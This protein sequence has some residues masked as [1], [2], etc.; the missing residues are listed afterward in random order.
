M[1]NSLHPC[2]LQ[3]TRPSCPS[4]TPG[5]YT[6]I[7]PLSQWCHPT[8]SSS[9][10]LFY[11][12][13]QFFPTSGSFPMSQ[14][15]VSGGQSIGVSGST[16]VLPMNTQDWSPL[17]WTGWIS[18]QSKGLSRVVSNTTVQKQQF[19]G[20]QLSLWSNS[21]IHMTTGNTT[22]MMRRTFVRKVMS[23]LFNMLSRLVITFLPRS[24][25]LLISWLQSPSAVILESKK[26]VWHCF[27][28]FPI[29][30]PQR[31]GTRC[32]DLSF[33]MFSFKA[34]ISLSSFTYIK[35]L[36]GSSSLSAIRVVSSAYLKLLIFL[37]GILIPAYA[38]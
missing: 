8:I 35:R 2:G 7:R 38:S 1:S 16:S 33:L 24:K 36:F 9:V 32:H 26:I 37:P 18:L 28:G 30:L 14:F 21:H 25:H 34:T 23:L 20:A 13:L 15:F 4:P 11:T 29:Y 10:V 22:A 12:Q 31:D 5:V 3:H 17:A 6:N 27:H 19:F